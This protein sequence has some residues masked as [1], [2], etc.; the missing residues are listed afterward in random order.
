MFLSVVTYTALVVEQHGF[1]F[2]SVFFGDMRQLTWAGQFNL[3]FLFLLTLGALW[4]AWRHRFS[5]GG[6]GLAMAALVGGVPF[7]CI[8]LWILGRQHQGDVGHML[9]GSRHP[10]TRPGPR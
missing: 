2:A 10:E 1:G 4:V 9:L 8:Y 7:Y 6:C 5:L 3:D